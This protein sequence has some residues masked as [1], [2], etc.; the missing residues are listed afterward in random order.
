VGR[1]KE[2]GLRGLSQG[3][4]RPP[5]ACR[6]VQNGGGCNK[7]SLRPAGICGE[8]QV[9]TTMVSVVNECDKQVRRVVSDYNEFTGPLEPGKRGGECRINSRL[10]QKVDSVFYIASETS[11]RA[12]ASVPKVGND[13]G[14]R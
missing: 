7:N 2:G 8:S 9:S 4:P 13:K 6:A 3:R 5:V 1:R 11:E 10:K 12:S 14:V